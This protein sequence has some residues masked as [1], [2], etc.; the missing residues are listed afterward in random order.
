[1]LDI[2]NA[3]FIEIIKN[4]KCH[5]C[6][7]PLVFNPHTRDEIS[8]YVSI[9]Y[10][11]DRKNNNLGYTKDIGKFE[12]YLQYRMKCKF[13]KKLVKFSI[14]NYDTLKEAIKAREEFIKSLF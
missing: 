6:D 11:L 9:A 3:K 7:K 14:G 5:Y 12:V 2:N 8:N 4:S 13:N 10:Q 1:M